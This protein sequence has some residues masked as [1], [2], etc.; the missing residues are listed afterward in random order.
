MTENAY[1][2][3][4]AVT[5]QRYELVLAP[6]LGAASF[7]G[8]VLVDAVV[9]EAADHVVLN[10]AE[11]DIT[12][13]T[14]G[15]ALILVLPP[16]VVRLL[17][18]PVDEPLDGYVI[19]AFG[20]LSY[21]CASGITWLF[22]QIFAGLL[23]AQSS[24]RMFADAITYGVIDPLTTAAL[25]GLLGLALWFRPSGRHSR[26]ARTV[27]T[28]CTVLMAVL[29]VG[30]W[31]I[32]ALSLPHTVEVAVNLVQAGVA[33]VTLRVAVQT[34]LLHETPDP[35]NGDAVLCVHCEKVVPDAPF[36]VSCGAAARASSRSSRRLRRRCP[37]VPEFT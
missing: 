18:L 19:G 5:P 6:D 1:R 23:D 36:C 9:H 2:L 26:Q 11:L 4:R 32:D 10:A 15:G 13:V 22:P 30:V 34:V 16:A 12:S 20:A 35:A 31:V 3:P 17:R 8:S 27:V 7:T 28:I 37:P 25:G 21:S 33:L 14:V 29:Y 24:W